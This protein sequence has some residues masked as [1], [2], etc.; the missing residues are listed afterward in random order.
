MRWN[1]LDTL[2]LGWTYLT[3]V[4]NLEILDIHTVPAA[5]YNRLHLLISE[6]F[7]RAP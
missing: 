7:L 5:G 6:N 2:R 3:F 1:Y 4:E